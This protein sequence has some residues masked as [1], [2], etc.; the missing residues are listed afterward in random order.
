MEQSEKVPVILTVDD[1]SVMNVHVMSS[2][3]ANY[4][5]V[6]LNSGK[7]ALKF[8]SENDVDLVILDINMPEV[9]GFQV[10]DEMRKIPGKKDVPVIFLTGVEKEDIVS[11]I[12]KSGANDYILKPI[13]PAEI[14]LHVQNQ[15]M[16]SRKRKQPAKPKSERIARIN[17]RR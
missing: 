14:L 9:S 2:L 6:T 15:L 10:Y 16:M 12:I 13:A 3:K 8:L 5:V 7:A 17:A 11:Q 1:D 4:R